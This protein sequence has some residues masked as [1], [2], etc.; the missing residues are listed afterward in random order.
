MSCY[1]ISTWQGGDCYSLN[2]VTGEGCFTVVTNEDDDIEGDDS[3]VDDPTNLDHP[4]YSYDLEMPEDVQYIFAAH[5][6]SK[7]I[8]LYVIKNDE[9]WLYAIPYMGR[10][11]TNDLVI[12]TDEEVWIKT[13]IDSSVDALAIID[14][15]KVYDLFSVKNHGFSEN[16]ALGMGW[17]NQYQLISSIYYTPIQSFSID[18]SGIDFLMF[19][20]EDIAY[21]HKTSEIAS[22]VNWSTTVT[23]P[24]VDSGGNCTVGV[25]NSNLDAWG[26]SDFTT[27]F[28]AGVYDI[29]NDEYNNSTVPAEFVRDNYSPATIDCSY[30]YVSPPLKWYLYIHR[31][32]ESE[33]YNHQGG[34]Y[35]T[36]IGTFDIVDSSK[37]II[38]YDDAILFN[39]Y[40]ADPVYRFYSTDQGNKEGWEYGGVQHK[41]GAYVDIDTKDWQI[42]P[43]YDGYYLYTSDLVQYSDGGNVT[44]YDMDGNGVNTLSA[45]VT[46]AR[47]GYLYYTEEVEST[48]LKIRR[49][50][51]A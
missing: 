50:D 16:T 31:A 11:S 14:D 28:V 20:D 32:I 29:T 1:K 35:D 6:D 36:V 10:P 39:A 4:P 47:D 18:S 46:T 22:N 24:R 19:Q 26:N 9:G 7:N 42:A 41:C 43:V 21:S 15:N 37:S 8:I 49:A 33:N 25:R 13:L 34:G 44:I 45:C 51:F 48:T 3:P 12:D 30:D 38:I 27:D 17:Y 23:I 40:K 5:I 2:V